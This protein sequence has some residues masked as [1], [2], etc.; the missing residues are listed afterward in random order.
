MMAGKTK[1]VL[2][3]STPGTYTWT[4]PAGVSSV[5]KL[6]GRGG[7]GYST[8]GWTDVT[9]SSGYLIGGI[10]TNYTPAG[11]TLTFVASSITYEE[12]MAFS[13][14]L[15]PQ[16]NAITT[17][18]NGA[19]YSN[20]IAWYYTYTTVSG[21]T[22]WYRWPGTNYG[23]FYRRIA[24]AGSTGT[25]N[26]ATGTI[27]TTGNVYRANS[28]TNIQQPV[29]TNFTGGNST[30]L[31]YSFTGTADTNP[32]TTTY[33]NIPVTPGTNYTIVVGANQSTPT[34]FIQL[35]Y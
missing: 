10:Y 31:G 23:G 9:S 22:G 24:T 34:S 11:E 3:Y 18:T 13:D 26:S 12:V 16:W 29:T 28:I 21:V 7:S 19:Y 20:L 14:T 17:N 5:T 33:T 4:A 25:L 2:L 30:A 8:S 27:P 6:I 35:E 15:I 1:T 32:T